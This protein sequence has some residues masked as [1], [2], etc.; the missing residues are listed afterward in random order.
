MEDDLFTKS[1]NKAISDGL[2]FSGKDIRWRAHIAVWSAIQAKK[3]GGDFVECGVNRGLLSK[4]IVDYIGFNTYPKSFFLLDTYQGFDEKYLSED[5]KKLRS[6][7]NEY[8]PCYDDVVKTFKSF[9][10][11]KIIKGSVP[12]TLSQVNS[13]KISYLSID[14]NCIEPEI[15][16]A[17]YFWDKM[18]VGGII[19]LDDYGH[20]GHE[21]QLRA[22]NK[23]AKEKGVSILCLPTGQGLIIKI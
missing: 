9:N 11:V 3:L 21:D 1:Y 17:E 15:E 10:N 22:F 12:E 16:C 6:V 18:I 8:P 13:D 20:S 7:K 5:E 2:A 14:M 4:I 23:F 19:L